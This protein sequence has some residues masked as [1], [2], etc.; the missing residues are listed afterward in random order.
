MRESKIEKHL[1]A[2]VKEMGGLCWKFTSPN[3]RGVPDRVV[4]LTLGR[5]CWVELKAPGKKPTALQLRRHAELRL[6]GHRVVVLDSVEAVDA[7]V[8][9]FVCA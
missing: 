2:R 4:I 3:L 6:R 7:F 1:S 5:F 9:E 8:G